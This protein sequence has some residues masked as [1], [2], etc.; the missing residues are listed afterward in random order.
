MLKAETYTSSATQ[1]RNDTSCWAGWAMK[2]RSTS[3]KAPASIKSIFPPIA[4][5]AGVPRTIIWHRKRWIQSF[6]IITSAHMCQSASLDKKVTNKVEVHSWHGNS[7]FDSHPITSFFTKFSLNRLSVDGVGFKCNQRL[8]FLRQGLHFSLF[9]KLGPMSSPYLR[10]LQ[11][12]WGR[13]Q[14]AVE[15]SK[16]TYKLKTECF[17]C[18]VCARQQSIWIC[19]DDFQL[20]LAVFLS[21]RI[22]ALSVMEMAEVWWGHEK[23]KDK[24]YF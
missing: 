3:A 11:N 21:W 19:E 10:H 13:R 12:N 1:G 24:T 4:S 5:S 9:F 2:T 8:P 22:F 16:K 15:S 7:G 17:I 18:Q 6:D 14:D 23:K 20:H